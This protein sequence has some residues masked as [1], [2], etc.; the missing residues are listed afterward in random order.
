MGEGEQLA[1]ILLNKRLDRAI[2]GRK[3][4][5]NNKGSWPVKEQRGIGTGGGREWNQFP[6][7]PRNN[8]NGVDVTADEE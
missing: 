1:R 7:R 4:S 3:K 2:Q 6:K 8:A 5:L